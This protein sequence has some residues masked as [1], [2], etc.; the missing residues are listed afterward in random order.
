MPVVGRCPALLP[1]GWKIFFHFPRNFAAQTANQVMTWTSLAG[2]NTTD[3]TP[4]PAT[5]QKWTYRAIFHDGEGRVG[6][7]SPSVTITVVARNARSGCR[8]SAPL[9]R[10]S[11]P[12]A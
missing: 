4:L 2:S 3:T 1:Y 10:L 8:A 11:A 12:L 9:A 5:A 7:W 6:Q